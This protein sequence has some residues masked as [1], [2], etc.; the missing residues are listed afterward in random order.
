MLNKRHDLETNLTVRQVAHIL[1]I[2]ERTVHRRIRS[3]DLPA[4]K[5]GTIVRIRQNDLRT[6]QQQR[7]LR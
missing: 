7:L 6:Y 4:L 3:G 5:D 1:N 2:S